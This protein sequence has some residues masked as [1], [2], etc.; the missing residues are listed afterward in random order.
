MDGLFIVDNQNGFIAM[1]SECAAGAGA[2]LICSESYGEEHFEGGSL[3]RMAVD[4]DG[5]LMAA[6]DADHGGEAETAS[7]EFGGEERIEDFAD[8]WLR[9]FLFRCRGLRARDSGRERC[10]HRP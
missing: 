3:P 6:D 10:R 2:A 8:R 4:L 9:P 1:R 7:R 5:A